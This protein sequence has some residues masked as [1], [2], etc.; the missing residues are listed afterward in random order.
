MIGSLDPQG[1]YTGWKEVEDSV[2]RLKAGQCLRDAVKEINKVIDDDG[3]D[4]LMEDND[5]GDG[6]DDDYDCSH[7]NNDYSKMND[8]KQQQRHGESRT[9]A[10]SDQLETEEP[11]LSP[12]P[13]HTH[14]P[15]AFGGGGGGGGEPP[16]SPSR[17][18]AT[19][20][21]DLPH[22]SIANTSLHELRYNAVGNAAGDDMSFGS[23][24]DEPW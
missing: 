16:L 17:A 7:Y 24:G 21:E 11:S 1:V 8:E 18:V 12:A 19:P 15:V 6:D 4:D 3:N 5:D 10:T 23:N 13:T 22:I 9:T 20:P 2:A 14:T